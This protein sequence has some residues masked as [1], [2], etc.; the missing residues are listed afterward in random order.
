MAAA[1]FS[2]NL[3]RWYIVVTPNTGYDG[4]A[5]FVVLNLAAQNRFLTGQAP[6]YALAAGD[7]DDDNNKFA[8]T[9]AA[10]AELSANTDTAAGDYSV[11]IGASEAGFGAANAVAVD[12]TVARAAMNAP[13]IADAGPDQLAV[14]EGDPVTLDGSGSSDLEGEAMSYAWTQTGGSPT[15]TLSSATVVNPTFTAPA[16]LANDATLVFSLIV[17]NES[18]QASAAATVT[19]AVASRRQ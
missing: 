12:V 13:P 9:G 16:Q 11:R 3:G 8:L 18:G 5:D 17:T 7:G 15:V 4:A 19:I 1:A 2:Q 14:A 6:A 10:L